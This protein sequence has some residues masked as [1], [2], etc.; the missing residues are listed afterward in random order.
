MVKVSITLPNNAQI[1]LESEESEVIQE[2]VGAV[3]RDLPRE[4]MQP[5]V[6]MGSPLAETAE[7]S[8]SVDGDHLPTQI[9]S[10][11]TA[12]AS[13]PQAARRR[14]ATRQSPAARSPSPANGGASQASSNNGDATGMGLDTD[15]LD[16]EAQRVFVEFCQYA[17]PLGDMRRVVVATVGASRS[18]GLLSVDAADLGHLFDMV[19][20]R[21]PHSFVQTMRNAARDKFRWLERIPGRTGKYA[22]S[23][24][25]ME[26]TLGN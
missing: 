19:G 20:W 23:E 5:V 24:L 3:L 12:I 21:H 1:T 11:E 2:I 22:A 26:V 15:N 10:T 17:N 25:G 18:L 8:S 9:L 13:P 14:A 6:P 4:L 16:P 7:K